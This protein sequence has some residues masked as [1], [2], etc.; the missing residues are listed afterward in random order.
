MIK[1]LQIELAGEQIYLLP[2]KAI[3]RPGKNQLV[4]SDVHLGKAAH[5]R[6]HGLPLP[7]H[8]FMRDLD[9]LH[10]LINRLQPQSVLFLGDLFHSHLNRE[11]LWFKAFLRYYDT[12]QFIL[13]EGNHDIL[14]EDSYR[15]A[16]LKKF[17][18]LEEESFIFSHE[19]CDFE[20]INR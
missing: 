4:V 7:Q 20:K 6:Q 13:I 17:D 15:M 2:Q 16:N 19:P 1:H 10:F 5:F 9:L 12:I 8:S 11:W 18:L 3:Y 14:P